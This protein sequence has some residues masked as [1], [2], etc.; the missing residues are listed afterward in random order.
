[1]SQQTQ[2]YER[3]AIALSLIRQENNQV[4]PDFD[5]V[6]LNKA[7]K[8]LDGTPTPIY[9]RLPPLEGEVIDPAVKAVPVI[10]A[11]AIAS[12]VVSKKPVIAKASKAKSTELAMTSKKT[13]STALL[14]ANDVKK[15]PV[16]QVSKDN[17]TNKPAIKTASNSRS[18]GGSPGGYYHGD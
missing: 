10:K 15:I 17:K 3:Y 16:K 7:L 6:V 4:L 13:K 12:N 5:Q 9:E 2:S 14:A 18:S 1:M 11:P 8:D